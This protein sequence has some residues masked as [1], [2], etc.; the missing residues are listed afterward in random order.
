MHPNS[1]P[2]A[3]A[4]RQLELQRQLILALT[5]ELY[6]QLALYLQVLRKGLLHAV[7]QACFHLATQAYPER[8][9]AMGPSRRRELQ[10][11]LQ[12]LVQRCTCLLTVEQLMGLAAQ[13][14]SRQQRQWRRDQQRLLLAL[15]ADQERIDALDPDASDAE[16][17][18]RERPD[19][20]PWAQQD[21]EDARGGRRPGRPEGRHGAPVRGSVQLGLDLPLSADLFGEGMEGLG[22]WLAGL[23]SRG[24]PNLADPNPGDPSQGASN[25]GEA[26]PGPANQAELRRREPNPSELHPGD[27]QSGEQH[28]NEQHQNELHQAEPKQGESHLGESHLVAPHQAEGPQGEIPPAELEPGVAPALAPGALPQDSLPPGLGQP[29]RTWDSTAAPAGPDQGAEQ[30]MEPDRGRAAAPEPRPG[31]QSGTTADAG[32]PAAV[33]APPD[34]DRALARGGPHPIA[35]PGPGSDPQHQSGPAPHRPD[36]PPAADQPPRAPGLDPDLDPGALR[37]IDGA[38]AEPPQDPGD[39]PAGP[40]PA[41]PERPASP[42][43]GRQG[44]DRPRRPPLRRGGGRERLAAPDGA[45]D[46]F[47]FFQT[48][49]AMAAEGLGRD[50]AGVASP[51]GT[52]DAG[53]RAGDGSAEGSADAAGNGGSG[54]PPDP[55][56][57]L[58]S[59]APSPQGPGQ[60]AVAIP[61]ELLRQASSLGQ[62]PAQASWQAQESLMPQDAPSLL[63]WWEALDGALQRRLRNLSNAVNGELVRLGINRSPLP[64]AL[65][66]AVLKGQ[67]DPL[68]APANLVRL[69]LPF[70]GEA[71]SRS[72]GGSPSPAFPHGGAVDMVVLLLRPADLEFEAPALRVCRRRLEQS[73]ARLRTMAQRHR[74]WQRRVQAL[75]AERQWFQDSPNQNP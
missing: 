55:A 21:R 48:L 43:R 4:E 52:A 58:G 73:R 22:S 69:Q 20:E 74:Y 28:Q 12:A 39:S 56:P 26:D 24:D 16:E 66:D 62:A 17:Q 10:E 38:A 29:D 70:G 34:P 6:R 67:L 15:A 1:S 68:P 64:I 7:Q 50:S 13:L 54:G 8:F 23:A 63:A 5:P 59:V 46:D 27:P 71:P 44:L 33:P 53:P 51:G 9:S 65:L 40:A 11:R 2:L 18:D 19:Q 25:Q 75:E 49:F 30:G 60:G 32:P 47:S 14:Q 45:A 35:P 3:E 37:D 61:L 36:A 31:E 57:E 42:G 72:P 41:S